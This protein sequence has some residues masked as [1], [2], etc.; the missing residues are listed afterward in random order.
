MSIQR[1]S[2]S[3]PIVSLAL[4]TVIKSVFAAPTAW[5]HD[6]APET[7]PG[8]SVFWWKLGL[9]GVLV[10]LG[11]VFAGL[12]LGLMGL[13]LVNLQVLSTSGTEQEQRD[14]KKVIKL[15]ERGRHWVLVVLLLSNVVVNESL[16][17]FLDSILGG[18]VGAVVVSTTL[19]VIFGEIAPQSVCARYGL[20]IG[21]A[22]A[23]FVLALM[24][25][26]FPIAYPIAKLL[27]YLLGEETGTLYKKAELKT[28]V[29]LHRQFGEETLS[30][31]EATIISSVLDLNDKSVEDIMT[32]LEDIYSLASDVK[33]NHAVVD[34]IL[35]SGHSRIPVHAPGDPTDF[36]GMLIVKKLISYDPEDEK[37]LGDMSLSILP[38]VGPDAS[39]L[40][41]LNFFQ[42]GRSHILLVSKT[43]GDPGGAIGV[44]SLEDVIEE[45]I[46]EEIVDETD[47]YVDI[48]MKTKVIRAPRKPAAGKLAPLIAGVIERRRQARRN[49]TADGTPGNNLVVV[50]PGDSVSRNAPKSGFDKVKLRGGG[51]PERR[52]TSTGGSQT[53][54]TQNGSNGSMNASPESSS[55][56]VPNDERRPL[57]K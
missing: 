46:G 1:L 24:Y 42:T 15:L 54:R 35:V 16:P 36:I 40:D 7:P 39:C 57:L 51:I 12:T 14:A 43:P 8:S 9:S 34:Q 31:D 13:D 23:P 47:L 41:L 50:D 11:G 17:I 20:R 38:E 53:P 56:H 45:M 32:P 29:G 27:D 2:R 33:L 6:E 48:H 25:L 22:T 4:G 49:N 5:G 19:I 28:F 10:L 55:F 21:A 30:E 37:T 26:E 44:V 18:G 3:T 52:I